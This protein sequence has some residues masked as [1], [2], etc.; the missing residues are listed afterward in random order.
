MA[1]K[2]AREL[3]NNQITYLSDSQSTLFTIEER[4]KTI[5]QRIKKYYTLKL[6]RVV[7][8]EEAKEI[9]DN[10]LTFAKAI[11]GA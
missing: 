9:G 2:G 5:L 8:E 3:L 6:G 4:E 10:L 7:D 1:V 11:Y